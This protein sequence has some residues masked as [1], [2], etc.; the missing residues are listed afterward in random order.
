MLS[1]III[2][3]AGSGF[4]LIGICLSHSTFTAAQCTGDRGPSLLDAGAITQVNLQAAYYESFRNFARGPEAMAIVQSRSV[5]V[6]DR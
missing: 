2:T 6:A 1:E 3:S 4:V 5:T